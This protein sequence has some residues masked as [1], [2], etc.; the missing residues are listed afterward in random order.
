MTTIYLSHFLYVQSRETIWLESN[1]ALIR[2]VIESN[3]RRAR[4]TKSINDIDDY[5]EWLRFQFH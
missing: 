4:G 5:T 1:S 2:T 3:M